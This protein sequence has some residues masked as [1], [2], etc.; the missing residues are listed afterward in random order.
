[1]AD[2]DPGGTVPQPA[3]AAPSLAA[4]ILGFGAVLVGG[5][6]G[7]IVG[8]TVTELQCRPGCQ[9]LAGSV[10]VASAALA[11]AGVGVVVVLALRAMAEWRVGQ[12]QQAARDHH[13]VD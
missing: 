5:A 7:G 4:R 2:T 9:L 10:G 8:Y 1:M 11:A 13:P 12:L 3:S 6:A